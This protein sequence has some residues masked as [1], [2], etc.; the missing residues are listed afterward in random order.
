MTWHQRVYS[1]HCALDSKVGFQRRVPQHGLAVGILSE[2][3]CSFPRGAPLH[4]VGLSDCPEI[5]NPHFGV[6]LCCDWHWPRD[7]ASEG[8]PCP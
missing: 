5:A 1:K 3:V 8:Y 6:Q 4:T 7:R 2:H